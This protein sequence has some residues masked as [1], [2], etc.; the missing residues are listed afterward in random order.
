MLKPYRAGEKRIVTQNRTI[1]D[2]LILPDNLEVLG[3]ENFHPLSVEAP[4]PS[5]MVNPARA[6]ASSVSIAHTTG[7]ISHERVGM[8]C[9]VLGAFG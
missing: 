8:L 9:P 7:L 5:C 6:I 2:A 4:P 3:W 1:I